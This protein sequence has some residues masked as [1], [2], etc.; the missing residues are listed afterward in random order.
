MRIV[1][2]IGVI[3]GGLVLASCSSTGNVVADNLPE[4]AGGLPQGTPPRRGEPGYEAYL[5]GI[6]GGQPSTAVQPA[7]TP[8]PAPGPPPREPREPVDQPIH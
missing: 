5:R 3:M 6:S 4:W 1:G 8:S 7:A 2:L